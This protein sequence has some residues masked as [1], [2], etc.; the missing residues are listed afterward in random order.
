MNWAEIGLNLGVP[1]TILGFIFIYLFR[2]L[3]NGTWVNR[4]QHEDIIADRDSYR[5]TALEQQQTIFTLTNTLEKIV[6]SYGATANH[7]L[8]S[9]PSPPDPHKEGE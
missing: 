3:A 7:V 9:L 1:L 5:K 8:N 4:K 2:T 6:N